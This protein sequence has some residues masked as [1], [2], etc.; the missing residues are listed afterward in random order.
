[1]SYILDALKKAERERNTKRVPMLMTVHEQQGGRWS[2]LAAAAGGLALCAAAAVWFFSPA[3]DRNVQT[4][5]PSLPAAE[6]SGAAEAPDTQ[7]QSSSAQAA[8]AAQ[9]LEAP[10]AD[11]E[12]PILD[13]TLLPGS[14]RDP[15]PPATTPSAAE[16]VPQIPFVR[17]A[18][19]AGP[20]QAP[21]GNAAYPPQGRPETASPLAAAEAAAQ[22][23]AGGA[24]SPAKDAAAALP[25][26]PVPLRDAV[27]KMKLTLLVYA[28]AEA[29][30]VAYINGRKYAKGDL[31]DGHYLVEDISAE[32][33]VLIFGGERT[34]LRP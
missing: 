2:R 26:Q 20:R 11:R 25:P 22:S 27:A 7:A 10:P 1:M 9:P 23:N 4:Q 3:L 21:A 24:G 34:M 8:S 32:G 13:A 12:A 19:E 29:E 17:T 15:R 5:R 33:V 18:P 28:E 31:V 16:P 14:R 6:R 30:R